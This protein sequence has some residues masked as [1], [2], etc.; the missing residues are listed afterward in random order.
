MARPTR[1]GASRKAAPAKK[2]KTPKK[3]TAAR[4]TGSDDSEVEEGEKPKKT[5]GFHV[6][7]LDVRG[8]LC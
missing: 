4:V 2:K 8:A 1:G 6:R 7:Y 5:T 3:K